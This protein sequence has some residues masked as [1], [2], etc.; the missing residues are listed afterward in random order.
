MRRGHAL[1][2]GR[3]VHDGATLV[4]F[5]VIAPTLMMLA[6]A[7]MQTALAF[8]AKYI[9][10]YATF[11]AAR[12]GALQNARP[13]SLRAAFARAMV[14]Y[15]GG[16][17]TTAELARSHGRA[18]TDLAGALRIEILSP[19]RES[20]DDFH[21]PRAAEALRVGARV[22]PSTHLDRLAC[23]IDRPSCASDPAS[24]RSGQTLQDANL[25]K[26]RVTFGIPRAKQIPLAGRFFNWAVATLYPDHP[27]SFRH[28]LLTAGRIPLVAHVTVRMQSDAIEN[29]ALLSLPGPGNAGVPVQTGAGAGADGQQLPSCPWSEPLCTP[30]GAH[31]GIPDNG[32]GVDEEMPDALEDEEP[33]QCSRS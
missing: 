14:P 28:A 31:E 1:Q 22:I 29:D 3:A 30:S 19:T 23:P 25:L 8:H 9:L 27:D 6:L 7:M 16:G 24:N 12:A 4:E 21:S 13:S 11:E 32:T 20:F 17:R 15:Y 33:L 18:I 5:V 10:N 2:S 26:I